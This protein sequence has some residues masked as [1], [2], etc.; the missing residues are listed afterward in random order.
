MPWHQEV[1]GAWSHDEEDDV[2]SDK[3]P[4]HQDGEGVGEGVGLGYRWGFYH[5]CCR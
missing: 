3:G 4:S 1:E 5:S 2:W